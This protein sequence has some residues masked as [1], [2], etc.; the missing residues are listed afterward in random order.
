MACLGRAAT[1]HPSSLADSLLPSVVCRY[2]RYTSR[3]LRGLSL[4]FCVALLRS[5]SRQV[6]LYLGGNALQGSFKLRNTLEQRQRSYRRLHWQVNSMYLIPAQLRHV[7]SCNSTAQGHQA[8]E[9]AL[10]MTTPRHECASALGM[11]FPGRSRLTASGFRPSGSQP[12]L[13]PLLERV[14]ALL[15]EADEGYHCGIFVSRVHFSEL[16]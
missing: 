16:G 14:R 5:V 7:K 2:C 10:M 6:A 15:Q 9:M 8:F 4:M 3:T 11:D 1:R 12:R 13:S